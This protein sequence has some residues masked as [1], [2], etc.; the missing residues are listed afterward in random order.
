MAEK[1]LNHFKNGFDLWVSQNGTCHIDNQQELQQP[2]RHWKENL[3]TDLDGNSFQS[4]SLS[5]LVL[6]L[7]IET[8]FLI[9]KPKHLFVITWISIQIY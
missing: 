7:E 2:V 1:G 5:I 4:N 3:P 6:F 8:F 9:N